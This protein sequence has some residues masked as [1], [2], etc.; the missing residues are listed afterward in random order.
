MTGPNDAIRNLVRLAKGQ[1]PIADAERPAA[2]SP[3]SRP[4][5]PTD[6]PAN[7]DLKDELRA[8]LARRRGG[9]RL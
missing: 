4:E 7:A 1:E 3:K 5:D 2:D 9:G 8:A 6:E